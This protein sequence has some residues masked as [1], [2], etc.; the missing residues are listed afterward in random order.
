MADQAKTILN[1]L[2]ERPVAYHAIYARLTGSANAGLF[3]SQAMYWSSAQSTERRGGW[4]YKTHS[5]WTAETGLSSNEIRTARTKLKRLSL[6]EEKR[7]GVPATIYY[8]IDQDRLVELLLQIAEKHK[9]DCGN[10]QTISET[11]NGDKGDIQTKKLEEEGP[12]PGSPV[13]LGLSMGVDSPDASGGCCDGGG[14]MRAA[15][16]RQGILDRLNEQSHAVG[17]YDFV[18]RRIEGALAFARAEISHEPVKGSLY[19]RRDTAYT[20]LGAIRK[21]PAPVYVL[22]GDTPRL[23]MQG[24]SWQNLNG[25]LR[26]ILLAG[27]VKLDL[28]AAQF[29]INAWLWHEPSI[30]DLAGPDV[31]VTLGREIGLQDKDDLKPLV[32]GTSYGQTW[33]TACTYLQEKLNLPKATAEGRMR[34][35]SLLSKLFSA[36][37]KFALRI[38]RS[39][40]AT[41]A[42]GKWIPA[43]GDVQVRSYMAQV[44]QSWE[45]WLMLP[46][47]A[48]LMDSGVPILALIHDGLYVPERT[49]ETLI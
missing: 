3:L 46:V 47:L 18:G 29:A 26:N 1:A 4:F 9:L 25:A 20:A 22:S 45:V 21:K 8:R 33:T 42:F 41:D 10:S 36:R 16:A 38:R 14:G 2:S 28:V 31:W 34:A 7:K 19:S 15:D 37:D 24:M 6:L 11:T 39:A 40:G 17:L 23:T 35:S 32:Y 30:L 44:S 12:G 43:C 5:E 27:S 49:P 48:E 13:S